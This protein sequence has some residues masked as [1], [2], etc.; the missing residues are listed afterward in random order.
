MD[1]HIEG[2][3]QPAGRSLTAWRAAAYVAAASVPVTVGFRAA[4]GSFLDVPVAGW[5]RLAGLVMVIAVT[6]GLI[7]LLGQ[8]IRRR[9]HWLTKTLLALPLALLLTIVGTVC[10]LGV[11]H[12]QPLALPAPTGPYRV[13]RTT[14]DWTDTDRI[15]PLA[16]EP[17]RRREL[18]IWIWYPAP[19]TTGGRP[20]PYAP[21]HW[22]RMLQFGILA[23]RLDVVRT[24]SVADAPVA[25]GRFPL[26]VL[27]PGMGLSVP[28]FA[29]LAE[30]LA[31]HGYAVAGV[32]PTY[33]ANVTVLNGRAVGP[34]L[35]GKPSDIDRARQDRLVTVWAA[36]ARFVAARMVTAGGS[37][38]GHVDGSRVVYLGHSFG[39][40]ASLQACHDDPHCAGAVDMDG[41]PYG[42]VVH[43]GLAA[44]MMLLGTPGD[45]V[46]GS[47]RPSDAVDRD[48]D[49]AS[50][51]LHASSTGPSFRYEIAGA[52]HLNFSDYGAY[53]IPAPLHGLAQLGPINGDRC[54]TVVS[55]YATTFADHVL[56]GGPAPQ[57]DHR[58]PE[59]H[60][61][62]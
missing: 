56:R 45:C 29:T 50:R 49:T 24:H 48:I 26:I 4:I 7:A 8:A 37:L 11:R 38:V 20:A 5:G 18:S 53:Y 59:A 21:G 39:G 22:A 16:P 60:L 14:F 35:A 32:T 28:Q 34:T 62:T 54:L 2:V 1:E 61:A 42:A 15:D 57:V 36:D 3:P 33:S 55:A 47:C 51:N 13:G 52:R 12:S 17:N 27:E 10:Y 43:Q 40:A 9:R 25:A 44:P 46:A 58:Y 31:S 30:D 23:S 19:A 41:T 6:S